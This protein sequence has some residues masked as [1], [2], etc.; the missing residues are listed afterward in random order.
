MTTIE[1]LRNEQKSSSMLCV[2]L[3]TEIKKMP[4]GL[5]LQTNGL[6]EFNAAII[7]ATSE[8]CSAY[9][10][11]FAF[12]EQYGEQAFSLIKNTLKFIPSTKLSIADAKRGDIGNTSGAYARAIFDDMGF[13]AV[14]V[15]PYMGY[16]S[17]APFLEFEN[18]IVFILALTSNA[19]S[20]DFQRMESN[21][22]P[23][24]RHVIEKAL[25]W[26][27]KAHIG[28]V[29]GATHPEELKQI[30]EYA[31]EQCLLIPGIGTQGGRA[32]DVINAN[33]N[34]PAVINVSR[35]I[36]YAS[37]NEDFAEAAENKARY[38]STLLQL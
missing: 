14:T 28:F 33:D 21:G 29:V 30:R 8:Y 2:G 7:K 25:S 6:L 18:K 15:N 36:L 16:D 17:I 22:K 9:K 10:I 1:L 34:K 5:R 4:E 38:Y 37:A 13:D 12:Y 26:Q 3:D 32:E 35:D 27:S 19:G 24:Y 20:D 11:N 23:L 31:G